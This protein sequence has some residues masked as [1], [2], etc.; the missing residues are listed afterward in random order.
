MK[1]FRMIENQLTSLHGDY[2]HNISTCS[3]FH[4]EWILNI[5]KCENWHL[6]HLSLNLLFKIPLFIFSPF[7][8]LS[9][10]GMAWSHVTKTKKDD[11]NLQMCCNVLTNVLN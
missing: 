2:S 3:C 8:T 4:F 11:I 6:T 9:L 7:E 1:Q 10:V 5:E